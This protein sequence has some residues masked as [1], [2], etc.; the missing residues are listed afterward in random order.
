M[1]FETVLFDL[2]GTLLNTLDDL[3]DA[4]NHV[5]GNHGY[6]LRTREQ[7]RS[8]LGNGA[9]DLLIKSLPEGTD[10]ETVALLLKEYQP[11]YL[12]HSQV[13]TAPYKGIAELLKELQKRGIKTAV[14]SN[15]SDLQ[16]RPLSE[17]FF[18]EIPVAIGE[19]NG[20]M[21]KPH[22]DMVNEA[23]RLLNASPDGAALMGDSE[24]DGKTAQNA[25]IPFLAA[26]WGFRDREIL[27]A[28]APVL[29]LE[30]PED[31]LNA[32]ED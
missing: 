15:K 1:K 27:E 10:E 12:E 7:V 17:K 20:M 9:R 22:T 31:L 23:L 13:K 32:W 16:V 29:F 5:L 18:P 19:R 2:D 14:V 21:K 26:G 25:G 3:T 4:V 30:K 24:V 6:P 11:W 8:A 28:F